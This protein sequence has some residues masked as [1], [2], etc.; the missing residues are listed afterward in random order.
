LTN[1]VLDTTGLQAPEPLLK[2][3]LKFAEME[4]GQILEVRGDC[5]TLENDVHMWCERM[6]KHMVTIPSH[7]ATGKRIQIEI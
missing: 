1:E 3:A 5:P 4:P 7:A 6:G 2:I